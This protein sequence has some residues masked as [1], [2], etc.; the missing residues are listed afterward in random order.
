MFLPIKDYPKSLFA[1]ISVATIVVG[2]VVGLQLNKDPGSHFRNHIKDLLAK[3]H[4]SEDGK[5][6][7]K[8]KSEYRNKQH[9]T[10]DLLNGLIPNE[11]LKRFGVDPSKV[12]PD[13]PLEQWEEYLIYFLL[14]FW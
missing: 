4:E 5:F 7:E 2:T 9:F 10:E 3:E 14:G 1:A 13:K 8:R 11:D 12:D 6:L